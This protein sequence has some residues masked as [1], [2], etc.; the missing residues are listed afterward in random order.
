MIRCTGS[1]STHCRMV[2]IAFATTASWQMAIASTSSRTVEACSPFPLRRWIATGVMTTTQAPP[3]TNHPRVLAAAAAWRL[4][5]SL[6]E[7][8][9]GRITFAGSTPCNQEFR[10]IVRPGN[11]H[12][13]HQ[14]CPGPRL[15]VARS[16]IRCSI[17]SLSARRN[18]RGVSAASR[19]LTMPSFASQ[20]STVSPLHSIKTATRRSTESP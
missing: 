18:C 13:V 1:S 11:N 3:T 2:S 15:R 16:E 7:P 5:K 10:M 17:F 6:M 12:K 19:K 4:L 9:A 20:P 8:S 14:P